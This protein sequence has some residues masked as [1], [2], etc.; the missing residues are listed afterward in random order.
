M[1]YS[2]QLSVGIQKFEHRTALLR[3]PS[4]DVRRRMIRALQTQG[5]QRPPRDGGSTD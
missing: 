4:L 5:S 3:A 1:D 2:L